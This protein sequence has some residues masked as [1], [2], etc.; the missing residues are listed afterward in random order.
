MR[1]VLLICLVLLI[2]LP[3][4][5]CSREAEISLAGRASFDEGDF[6]QALTAF[7]GAQIDDPNSP[8]LHFSVGA[9]NYKQESLEEAEQ[10]LL[11][12]LVSG[13]NSLKEGAHYNLGN[14]KFRQGDLEAAIEQYIEALKIN[15]NN[16]DAR[17][18]LELARLRL[19]QQ[20]EQ[21]QQNEEESELDKLLKRLE[22]LI[23]RQAL[24]KGRTEEAAVTDGGRE[25]KPEPAEGEEE[26]QE[27]Q[28]EQSI[29]EESRG[30]LS[31]EQDSITGEALD[32]SAGFVELREQ[33]PEEGQAPPP[34]PGESDPQQELE[35]L[36]KKLTQAGILVSEGASSSDDARAEI[37]AD[38]PEPATGSQDEAL[39]KFIEARRLFSDE[40]QQ[41]NQEQCEQPQGGE[42]NQDE[43][44]QEEQQ[45]EGEQQEEQE[46]QPQPNEGG[47]SEQE[48]QPQPEKM[49]EEEAAKLLEKLAEQ[50]E[51]AR[52]EA[53]L[54]RRRRPVEKDW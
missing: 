12:V 49:T 34:Q 26:Q 36:R 22:E 19:Q 15:E 41:K 33:L 54:K 27:Q 28:P 53:R 29:P 46:R 6:E 4:A 30:E 10:E 1:N 32:V 38:Q 52:R 48:A 9:V 45:G 37:Q 43:Q 44:Q 47:Q 40:Q 50:E 11:E 5:G 14:V 23:S 35:E 24:N 13:D 8:E 51:Q 21:E 17:F 3:W 18:N 42:E 25:E 7:S 39:N 31:G 20:Q 2:S 16:E